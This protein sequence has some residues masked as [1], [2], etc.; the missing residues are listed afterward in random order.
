MTVNIIIM[1]ILVFILHFPSRKVE[2]PGSQDTAPVNIED[3]PEAVVDKTTQIPDKT[4][5]KTPEVVESARDPVVKD[6]KD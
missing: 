5:K 3:A 2:S 1:I 4:E 6:K